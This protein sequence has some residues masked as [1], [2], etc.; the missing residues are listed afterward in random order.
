M[1]TS[2]RRGGFLITTALALVAGA[3]QAADAVMPADF[4]GVLPQ[5]QP[6]L[7]MQ[8]AAN[9]ERW[10]GWS[11]VQQEA[12]IAR[13]AAWDALSPSE[14]AVQRE[15]YAA[16]QSLPPRERTAIRA[17]AS[18]FSGLRREH[19]QAI[20]ARFDGLDRSVQRGWLLGPVLG[21]DYPAL[22]PLLAQVPQEEHKPLLEV[23][24]AMSP[25]QR[26]DVAVLVARTPPQERAGLRRELVST[27]ASNRDRWLWSRLER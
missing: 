14:R 7:R 9:A 4:R 22:Q 27:P 25:A 24:R 8:L 20:R 23:L 1:P 2:E 5:L 18:R 19:R 26:A 15:R 10:S 11:A 16:W 13:A 12:F 6:Q 3:T 17:A 21:R